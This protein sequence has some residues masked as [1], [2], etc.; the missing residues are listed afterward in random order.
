MQPGEYHL[1][2]YDRNFA[3][4]IGDPIF[5]FD[6]NDSTVIYNASFLYSKTTILYKLKLGEGKFS[7]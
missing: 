3:G 2:L 4:N 6:L 1:L 5:I 7:F